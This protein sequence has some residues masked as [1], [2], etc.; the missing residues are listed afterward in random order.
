[1]GKIR[2]GRIILNWSGSYDCFV[3]T[4]CTCATCS[5]EF[6]LLFQ[7]VIWRDYG[8][9]VGVHVEGAGRHYICSRPLDPKATFPPQFSDIA[10]PLFSWYIYLWGGFVSEND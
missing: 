3:W 9:C 10:T 2:E 5:K 1:V 4:T 7:L 6:I 8:V